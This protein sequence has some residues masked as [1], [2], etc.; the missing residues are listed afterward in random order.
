MEISEEKIRL[1][2]ELEFIIGHECYNP[3]SYDGYAKT[4]G[5]SYRYPVSYFRIYN[6][7]KDEFKEDWKLGNV[8]A[9]I[10]PRLKYKFGSNHLYIGNALVNL[11]NFLEKRYDIDFN[12]LE[13]NI[14]PE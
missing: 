13:K 14:K 10:L 3:N 11:I 4:Y 1:I 6:G 9:E 2:K 12:E 5:R 8:D 7:E